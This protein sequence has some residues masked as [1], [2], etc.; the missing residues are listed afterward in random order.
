MASRSFASGSRG[1]G[2]PQA[3]TYSAPV[4]T[5]PT[6]PYD[7]TSNPWTALQLHQVKSGAGGIKF[8]DE[9]HFPVLN[10]D[11]TASPRFVSSVNHYRIR[12]GFAPNVF[13][14]GVRRQLGER[15]RV[16]GFISRFGDSESDKGVFMNQFFKSGKLEDSKLSFTTDNVH[17]VWFEFAGAA[18]R[19]PGKK[20]DEDAYYLLR[21]TLTRFSTD[22]DKKTTSQINTVEFRSFP[23][24][25]ATN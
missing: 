24:D 6:R 20:P 17:G 22:A 9:Q 16:T 12:S 25:A 21:G 15:T 8:I 14:L 3:S 4:L 5:D 11:G 1:D 7:P 23:R 19:G 2:L 13:G 10:P 18:T